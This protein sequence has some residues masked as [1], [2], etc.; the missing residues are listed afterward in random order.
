MTA[1]R[2]WRR[3]EHWFV[4]LCAADTNI[5]FGARCFQARV[6]DHDRALETLVGLRTKFPDDVE[7]DT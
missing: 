2:L 6:G 1:K 4:L 3:R 7:V 5:G